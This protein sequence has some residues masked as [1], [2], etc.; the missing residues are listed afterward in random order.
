MDIAVIKALSATV[1]PK[2][3]NL[4]FFISF[5]LVKIQ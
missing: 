5:A 2:Q 3:K 1:Q 4:F